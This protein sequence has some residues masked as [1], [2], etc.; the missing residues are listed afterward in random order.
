VSRLV[1]VARVGMVAREGAR[2]V[3]PLARAEGARGRDRVRLRCAEPDRRSRCDPLSTCRA[4]TGGA[5]GAGYST[6]D[7]HRGLPLRSGHPAGRRLGSKSCPKSS[8]PSAQEGFRRSTKGQENGLRR[9]QP[10]RSQPRG[11]L[12]GLGVTAHSGLAH[13]R[14][15]VRGWLSVGPKHLGCRRWLAVRLSV[16]REPRR[17]DADL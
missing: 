1:P 6:P 4:H 11:R 3:G 13:R 12:A 7:G 17:P 8:K 2:S 16:E 14:S 15:A 9:L 5:S 10:L